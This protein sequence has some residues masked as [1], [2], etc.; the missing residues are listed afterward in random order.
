MCPVR[1][2]RTGAPAGFEPAP[3]GGAAAAPAARSVDQGPRCL[4]RLFLVLLS[5][6]PFALCRFHA[7]RNARAR[8]SRLRVHGPRAQMC[9]VTGKGSDGSRRMIAVRRLG[10]ATLTTPD[11]DRRCLLHQGRHA[12]YSRSQP[13]HPGDKAGPGGDRARAGRAQ[14]AVAHRLQVAPGMIS[15]GSLMRSQARG[16]VDA[17]ATSPGVADAIVFKDPR[18]P[19]S[20]SSPSTTSPRGREPDRHHAVKLGHVAI[21]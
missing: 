12:G 1:T 20:R 4:G 17:K 10:H 3:F 18:G 6:V 13:C 11:I 21:A 5:P 16:Q 15:A 7:L 19:G 2:A 14:R 9:S 8:R